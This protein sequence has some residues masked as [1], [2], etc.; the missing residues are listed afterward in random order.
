MTLLNDSQSKQQ[1]SLAPW[2][3]GM[4]PCAALKTSDPHYTVQHKNAYYDSIKHALCKGISRNFRL[5][6]IE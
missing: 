3:L 6:E 4:P 1:H 2:K 5:K